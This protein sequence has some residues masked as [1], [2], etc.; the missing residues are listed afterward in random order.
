MLGAGGD[1]YGAVVSLVSGESTYGSDL[2]KSCAS[3]APVVDREPRWHDCPLEHTQTYS[4][5]HT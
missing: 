4:H 3:A 1:V 2:V 5:T